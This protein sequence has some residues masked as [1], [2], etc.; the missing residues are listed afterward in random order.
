MCS[1]TWWIVYLGSSLSSWVSCQCD[2]QVH[3]S[4]ILQVQQSQII[5]ILLLIWFYSTI[6]IQSSFSASCHRVPKSAVSFFSGVNTIKKRGNWSSTMFRILHQHLQCLPCQ[7]SLISYGNL[8]MMSVILSYDSNMDDSR[9]NKKNRFSNT[10]AFME[11]YLNNV[12]N[13]D[14]PFH[15]EEKNK[16]TYEVCLYSSSFSFHNFLRPSVFLFPPVITSSFSFLP[17][18]WV[19][20]DIWSTLVST[21]SLS[22]SDSPEPCWALLTVDP[23]LDTLGYYSMM[24]DQVLL[25]RLLLTSNK[26]RVFFYDDF[27][28][29]FN[30]VKLF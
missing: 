28:F 25:E 24:M 10:M 16:L 30:A 8:L 26:Y 13:D 21:V 3:K 18:W 11:E 19:W 15:N 27:S 2:G 12:L 7:W 22:C 17:R 29:N 6:S 14:L 23:I 9:D 4:T 20:P 5:L 1:H